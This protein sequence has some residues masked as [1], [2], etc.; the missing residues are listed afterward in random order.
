MVH[1]A[2]VIESHCLVF[3][4]CCVEWGSCLNFVCSLRGEVLPSNGAD[5]DVF[6]KKL[7]GLHLEISKSSD[8]DLPCRLLSRGFTFLWKW[9][10]RVAVQL[11]LG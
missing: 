10:G 5:F 8:E 7:C 1:Q 11:D 4:G 9:S 3:L 2:L 6:E